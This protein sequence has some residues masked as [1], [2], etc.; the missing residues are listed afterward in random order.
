MD[1]AREPFALG[2]WQVDAPGNRLL[3]GS[4]VRPLRHKA[5]ALLVLLARHPGRTV[6]RDEIIDAIW[7]GNRFVAPKAI[8]TAVWTLRQA[9]DDDTESP[10][11][12]QTIAKKGYRLIA[13]VRAVQ[14]PD[15]AW[16]DDASAP[17]LQPP[18]RRR[19]FTSA[20]PALLVAG[21]ALLAL[22]GVEAWQAL[23]SR[24]DARPLPTARP[25]THTPGHE[26]LGRLS[27]DGR[28]LAFGWWQGQGVGQLHL[29]EADDLDARPLQVS[30]DAGEVQGLAWSPDSRAVAFVASAAGGRCS[31]WLYTLADRA[32]RELARCTPLF[33]PTVDWSPDGRWIVFTAEADGAGGLFLVAPDGQGLRRL[34]TA[35]PAA[36]A[37]HQPA[38]SPD[39]QRV[40]FARQ[41]PADGTRDLYETTLDGQ[42]SR[43]STLRLHL[44]HGLS[45]T[46]DGQDLVFSTTRQDTR[47][48]LRWQRAAARAVPLG[49]E[50]SAPSLAADGRLVYALLRSHVSIARLAW[51]APGPERVI[52]SV[53]SDRSPDWHAASG[54]TVF[55]SRRGGHPELWLA[56]PP[57]GGG[58]VVHS[59]RALTH[60]EGSVA[61]PAWSPG[62]DRVAFL[63]NC[64][65]GRRHGLCVLDLASGAITP[66]A[67]DAASY[68]RPV[69]HPRRDDVWVSSDRGGRW[70][71]WRFAAGVRGA[72]DAQ[73]VD[74]AQPPAADLQWA[75]D[76]SAL[77]YRP[78]FGS[79]LQVRP[80]AGGAERPLSL[81]DGSASLVDWRLGPQGLVWLSRG[82][83]ERFHAMP[84]AGGPARLLSEH[85]LGTFPERAS[86][87][88]TAEGE[89]LVEVANTATADLMAAR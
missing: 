46:A 16:P 58:T 83:R 49:L 75:A 63:G 40:A 47:Q 32:R 50:G 53:S 80:A 54:R 11:Y 28:W 23:S 31:V 19:R 25:L 30:A 66:L 20:R 67:A 7:D 84:L 55:V 17:S 4:E 45:Y 88:L 87:T 85:A 22:A 48:L 18:P 89:V 42:V 44:L 8:N 59:E 78:R 51:G 77:V 26:Y 24:D 52:G 14:A 81:V 82:H 69:W 76:G 15:A 57:G 56:E 13:P 41:D 74:T 38:W 72:G 6:T 73:A 43:L 37:D 5:M 86:F 79:D 61:A 35:P 34:T 71:V 60:I 27:P 1:P 10:R 21:V 2:D 3:R 39:G 65:P 29:R 33:T 9:L 64:G 68:G 12:V 70:Q 36:M 62:G